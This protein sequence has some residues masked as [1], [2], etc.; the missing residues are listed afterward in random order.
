MTRLPLLA[1]PLLIDGVLLLS[2]KI[3][4]R[5]RGRRPPDSPI[6]NS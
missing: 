2:L 6:A 1:A 3:G 4:D 5:L